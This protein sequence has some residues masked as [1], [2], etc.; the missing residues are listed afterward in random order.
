MSGVGAHT[1]QRAVVDDLPGIVA[2]DEYA[3]SDPGRVR[4]LEVWVKRGECFVARCDAL[5]EGFVVLEHS[6]FGQGFIPLVYVERSRRR[7]GVGLRLL[8]TAELECQTAKLFT[9]T[10]AS[11]V[12][13]RSLFERAGFVPSGTIENLDANDPELVYFKRRAVGHA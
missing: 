13:A 1:V 7:Q 11:N 12:A 9:S 4:S 6:F 10:N 3:P 8:A 2:C 5:L